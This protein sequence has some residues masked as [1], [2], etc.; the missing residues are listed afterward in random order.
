MLLGQILTAIGVIGDEDLE[1]MLQL[2]S[3]ETIYDLFSWSEGEFTF[4]D[5]ELPET[6]RSPSTSVSTDW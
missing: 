4:L 5:D 1:Y 2:K 6:P 3:E